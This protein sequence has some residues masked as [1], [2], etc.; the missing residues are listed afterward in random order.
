MTVH[1]RWEEDFIRCDRQR[2]T[3][4]MFEGGYGVVMPLELEQD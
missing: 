2:D 4:A 1:I 3:I